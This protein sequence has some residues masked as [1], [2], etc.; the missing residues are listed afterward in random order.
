MQKRPGRRLHSIVF[1]D[2]S[3]VSIPP[4]LPQPCG[5]PQWQPVAT[6]SASGKFTLVS[7]HDIVHAGNDVAKEDV[8][9]TSS[10]RV[11]FSH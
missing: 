8:R 10:N 3:S 6:T 2:N 1:N 11:I 7:R 4:A 5:N 9:S